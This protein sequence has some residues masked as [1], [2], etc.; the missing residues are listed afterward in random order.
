MRKCLQIGAV[1]LILSGLALFDASWSSA[2]ANVRT[3]CDNWAGVCRRTC[4]ARAPD[5]FTECTSR[6]NSCYSSQCFTFTRDGSRCYSDPAHR[7]AV[8]VK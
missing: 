2:S 7:R 8:N 6:R 4:P 1:A 3:F 5:C